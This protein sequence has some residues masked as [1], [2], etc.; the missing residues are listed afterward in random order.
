MK[1][2]FLA[3]ALFVATSV[4]AQNTPST[5]TTPPTAEQRRAAMAERAVD[6]MTRFLNLDQNQQTQIKT[7]LTET[8]A[9]N[10]T[11]QTQLRDLRKNLITAVKNNDIG[12]ITSITQQMSA[13]RQ[14]LDVSRATSAAKIFALLNPDQK[15]KLDN[16]LDML[17]EMGG[18][19]APGGP[20]M[21]GGF[22]P[23]GG[24]R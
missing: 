12:G 5:S 7:I 18:P 20:G 17:M 15:T 8:Q 11:L 2:K 14:Q 9:A 6:R 22:G 16:G 19:G 24:R 3:T 10:Q 13:P 4:F 23:R 1:T 21:R